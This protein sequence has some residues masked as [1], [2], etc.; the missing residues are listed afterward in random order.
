MG[1]AAWWTPK[2]NELGAWELSLLVGAAAVLY[3]LC[4]GY[5][6]LEQQFLS[7]R[8]TLVTADWRPG[9]SC[10]LIC[11]EES[12]TRVF[13]CGHAMHPHCWGSSHCICGSASECRKRS[14]TPPRQWK[15][16]LRKARQRRLQQEFPLMSFIHG[17]HVPE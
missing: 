11:L 8:A 1:G 17:T 12:P 16:L 7:R 15:T 6:L 2:R 10:C 14:V 5:L 13:L 4:R 3:A 9:L